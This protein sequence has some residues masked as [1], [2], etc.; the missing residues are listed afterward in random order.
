MH[1][2]QY[3]RVYAMYETTCRTH[4]DKDVD[5]FQRTYVKAYVCVWYL[6]VPSTTH[7]SLRS[8]FVVSSLW[9]VQVRI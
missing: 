8:W 1:S 3:Q 2:D 6:C 4:P 9:L 5:T 7:N